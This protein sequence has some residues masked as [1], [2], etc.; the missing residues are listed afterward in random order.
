MPG[1]G[2]RSLVSAVDVPLVGDPE[3]LVATSSAEA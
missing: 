2:S 1:Q 3:Y